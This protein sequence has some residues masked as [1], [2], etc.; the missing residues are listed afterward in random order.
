MSER[1]DEETTREHPSTEDLL[2]ETDRLL[3]DVGGSSEHRNQQR[4]R[5]QDS[6][7][8]TND[9]SRL[10]SA[11]SPS[12]AS[13]SDADST[14]SRSWWPW[15][16]SADG[17]Q[18]T[19]ASSSD[20]STSSTSGRLSRLSPRQYFSPTAFLALVVLFGAGLL[21]GSVLLP[22]VVRLL[23]MFAVAFLVGSVASKRRYLEVMAAGASVGIASSMLNHAV[24]T[25][26]GSGQRVAAIGAAAGI[27]ACLV[28]YY[29]GRDLRNGL[30]RE[31]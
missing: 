15:S 24:L 4:N 20:A 2:E 1:S 18:G 19:A 8:G 30:S 25:V 12:E 5:G 6:V 11:L 17:E 23:G 14:D 3:E 7:A 28:G 21:A 10:G 22:S 26:V 13:P 16:R 27:V 9:G 29:F 31:V